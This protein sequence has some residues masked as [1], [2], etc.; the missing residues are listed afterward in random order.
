MLR[1]PVIWAPACIC[2]IQQCPFS[3][4]FS[5]AA[6]HFCACAR[7]MITVMPF[8]RRTHVSL[9]Y[10]R[11]Y[12]TIIYPL[13]AKRLYVKK[14]VPLPVLNVAKCVQK[15]NRKHKRVR[16]F[17][18]PPASRAAYHSITAHQAE[19]SSNAC[20]RSVH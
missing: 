6:S 16:T 3:P 4:P 5:L 7:A 10:Y 19:S 17:I 11:V 18:M 9:L 1:L 20:F 8:G 14:T 13:L 12:S 15:E 2:I